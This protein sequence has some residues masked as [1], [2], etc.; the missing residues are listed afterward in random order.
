MHAAAEQARLFSVHSSDLDSPAEEGP[1]ANL[2]RSTLDLL[3]S[4]TQRLQGMHDELREAR[5]ALDERKLVERAKQLLIKQQ[6]C[7]ES[8]A[9]ARL[10]Q[11]AMN[12]GLRL[13]EVAQRLLALNAEPQAAKARQKH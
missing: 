2:A 10:R 5:Q 13:D 7:S 4:Q 3:Q 6:G 11:A 12:Q 1:G 8:E 9:Y